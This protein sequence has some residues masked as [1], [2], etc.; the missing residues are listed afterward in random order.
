LLNNAV[1]HNNSAVP[2]VTV[3]VADYDDH[4]EVSVADNGPGISDELKTAI[5]TKGEKTLDSEGTGIGLYLVS[6]L[7]EN[8]GGAVWVEDNE[9]VGAVFVV[10]LP[11]AAGE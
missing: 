10:S 8:Y 2:E 6:T 4:L 1:Q 7:V 11:K 5:F 3:S 9:P